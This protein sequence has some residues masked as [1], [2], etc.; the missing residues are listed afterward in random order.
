MVYDYALCCGQSSFPTRISPAYNPS[1]DPYLIKY[2]LLRS[3]LLRFERTAKGIDPLSVHYSALISRHGDSLGA[4]TGNKQSIFTQTA[5]YRWVGHSLTACVPLDISALIKPYFTL[6]AARPPPHSGPMDYALHSSTGASTHALGK[7]L[8]YV[9]G[10]KN[11]DV[12]A[13]ELVVGPE[14]VEMDNPPFVEKNQSLK[15][16]LIRGWSG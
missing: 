9:T 12:A 11:G 5:L 8:N 3:E 16:A 7:A 13:S 4:K 6:L 10:N 2:G 15:M 1:F 14:P